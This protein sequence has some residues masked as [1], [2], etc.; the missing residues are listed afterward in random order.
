MRAITSVSV[1]V[2]CQARSH[3][4]VK[5][6]NAF[7]SWKKKKKKTVKGLMGYIAC[8]PAPELLAPPRRF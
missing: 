2:K 1:D 7:A 8:K 6:N 4:F 3:S 5:H